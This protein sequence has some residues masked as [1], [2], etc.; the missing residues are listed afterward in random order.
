MTLGTHIVIGDA[1]TKILGATHPILGFFVGLVSH[2]L[3]D[4]IPHWD[5]SLSSLPENK[6]PTKRKWNYTTALLFDLAKI[7]LDF[8][9]GILATLFFWQLSISE[10]WLLLGAIILGSTLP[11]LL[12]G[13]Y[14]TRRF[15]QILHPLHQF[16]NFVHTKIKLGPYPLL[17]IPFQIIMAAFAI[18]FTYF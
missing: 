18:W 1:A 11:D 4:F 8:G 17:G 10:S 9:V 5:Y 16:H 12:G 14:Y 13:V 2:Y 3:S 6:D 15:D 7:A